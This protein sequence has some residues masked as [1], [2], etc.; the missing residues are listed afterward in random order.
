MNALT[1]VEPRFAIRSTS[2]PP[3]VGQRLTSDGGMKASGGEGLLGFVS[4]L[5]V[6]CRIVPDDESCS[7]ASTLRLPSIR[8]N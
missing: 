1:G 7:G 6:A 5:P 4:V 3:H 2:V 8:T